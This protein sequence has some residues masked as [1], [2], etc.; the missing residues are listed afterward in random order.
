[1]RYNGVKDNPDPTENGPLIHV[2]GARSIPGFQ[3]A[4]QKCLDVYSGELGG[5]IVAVLGLSASS[6]AGLLAQIHQLG[7]NLLIANTGHP[8]T[9][10]TAQ[11]PVAAPI[12]LAVHASWLNR[13]EL[14]FSIVQR[15]ALTPEPLPQPPGADRPTDHVRRALPDDCPPVRLDLHSQRPQPGP[16]EDRRPRARPP[17]RGLTI[18]TSGQLY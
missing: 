17:T 18:K 14:Y 10:G 9:G 13:I 5:R 7:T 2:E 8:V 16:R 11:L 6:Q 1:M 12:H 15:K 3:A 4:V